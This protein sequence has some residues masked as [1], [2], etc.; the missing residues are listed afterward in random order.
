MRADRAI[1]GNDPAPGECF[2][3]MIVGAAIAK[4]DLQHGSFNRNVEILAHMVENDA[5]GEDAGD[6]AVEAA[7]EGRR[8]L[9]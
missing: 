8:F 6:E 2:A 4:P 5:L 1:E 9:K 3:Q 7:H